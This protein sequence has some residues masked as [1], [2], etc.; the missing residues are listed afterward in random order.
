MAQQLD[1]KPRV[2]HI[3]LTDTNNG[4]KEEY[5]TIQLKSDQDQLSWA[6]TLWKFRKAVFICNLICMV[7]ACDGYQI[8]LNGELR[9]V[10][11]CSV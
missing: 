4:L 7:G 6:K 5:D 2:D 9:N 1:A 3:E 11:C 8:N 10:C